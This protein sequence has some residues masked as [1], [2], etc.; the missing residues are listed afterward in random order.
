MKLGEGDHAETAQAAAFSMSPLSARMRMV[1]AD[2][3]DAAADL[4]P[5]LLGH[6]EIGIIEK[7]VAVRSRGCSGR[8]R[9]AR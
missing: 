5:E 8:P 4:E 2:L 7:I 1:P 3:L 9:S 6:G